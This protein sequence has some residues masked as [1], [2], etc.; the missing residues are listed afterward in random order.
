M[1]EECAAKSK[2]AKSSKSGTAEFKPESFST[3]AKSNARSV[4]KHKTRRGLNRKKGD[5]SETT[6][7]LVA[8]GSNAAGLNTKKE[9][10]FYLVNT[11][12]PSIITIQ[13][14]KF[15]RPRSLNLPGYEVF[16]QPRVE[17]MGGGLLTAVLLDLDPCIIAD[18]DDVE[19]L[20]VQC[21]LGNLKLRIVNG[22]GPQEDDG[23]QRLNIIWETDGNH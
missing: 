7:S 17:K 3:E 1:C 19:L 4:V 12:K 22:Y 2:L 10:L 13:E 15:T 11:I 5:L 8:M 14:T 9:S 6:Q 16:E 20:V 21:S 23:P 18:Y